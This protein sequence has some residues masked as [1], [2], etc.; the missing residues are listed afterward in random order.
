MNDKAREAIEAVL[1]KHFTCVDSAYIERAANEIAALQWAASQQAAGFPPR[2]LEHLREVAKRDPSDNRG[3][4]EYGEGS[5][6][7]DDAD[8][9]LRWI[10]GSQQAAEG[11][12]SV[13]DRLPILPEDCEDDGVKVY[14]WDGEF[15]TEDVFEPQYEQPAGPAVGGWL[16]TGDWFCSDTATRVTHW[17]LRILPAPPATQG[18]AFLPGEYERMT[19]NGRKAWEGVD[20]QD[21]RAGNFP[22]G[23]AN[24]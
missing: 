13:H 16:R 11:W 12:I 7:Q 2:M 23:G 4:W 20:P 21:L 3:P 9:A 6:M 19:E 5:P 17:M 22:Q 1:N 8:A 10:A 18:G 24:E 15:V 14:T